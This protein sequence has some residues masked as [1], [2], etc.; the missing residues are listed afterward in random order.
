MDNQRLPNSM[1]AAR[2]QREPWRGNRVRAQPTCLG[3]KTRCLPSF[4]GIEVEELQSRKQ[5]VPLDLLIE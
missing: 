3:E 4:P 5:I 1:A 2:K